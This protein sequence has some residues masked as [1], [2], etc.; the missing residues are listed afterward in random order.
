MT[1]P[2]R[3]QARRSTSNEFGLPSSDSSK[4]RLFLLVACIW[5]LLVFALFASSSPAA[6]APES[7]AR[8]DGTSVTATVQHNSLRSTFANALDRVDIMG[9]G[10]THPRVAVVIV[11]NNKDHLV[12][13]LESV[14]SSTDMNRIF[15]VCVVADGIAADKALAAELE[16]IDQGAIPHWHGLRPDLHTPS[17]EDNKEDD[18]HGRKVHVLFNPVEQ[19]I[20]ASRND[21]VQFIQI[22]SKYHEDAGLKSTQEDLILLLLASGAQLTSRRWLS[23]VTKALIVP[24]PIYDIADTTVSMKLANAVSFNVE[25]PGKRTSFDTSLQR[26]ITE[27]TADEVNLSSGASYPAPALNG[28]ATALR[29]DTYLNLPLQDFGMADPWA[30]DLD[31]ALNLWLCGDGIDMLSQVTVTAGQEQ[32]PPAPATA[33]LAGRFAAA[34]MDDGTSKKFFHAYA[35]KTNQADLT[36]LEWQTSEASAESSPTFTRDLPQKCRSFAW[37]AQEINPDLSDLLLQSEEVIVVEEQAAKD[38]EEATESRR[39][40]EIKPDLPT[41]PLP[42]PVVQEEPD[43]DDVSIPERTGDKQKPS[44]PLCE[45]CLEIIQKAKPVDITFVDVSGG[46][47]EHPHKG[48]L[49]ADGNF[50]FIH[51]E[52]A[53]HKNPPPFNFA[54]DELKHECAKRD[55]NYR[56][57][58]EQVKVDFDA[59]A[60]AEK[61]GRKRDKIFCLVYTID[62][63]HHKIP[64]IRETWGYVL[65][66]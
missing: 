45:E 29:L 42:P 8:G 34:W 48:A 5:P 44:K 49:D 64:L 39:E 50:G 32:T 60:E 37:Y 7:T 24:P 20:T 15:V 43:T 19:G 2:K 12:Q 25:G 6:I 3:P 35:A 1:V 36:Y 66:L 57:L 38:K 41:K 31:L 23:P 13:T 27:P 17:E 40:E 53:L 61:S 9:Y 52:K 54:G 4:A 65:S 30:A 18:P 14:F 26:M 47:K 33:E 59:E 63:G 21:A 58:N 11:G 56:M 46:H 55:N 16:K 62:S 28:A 51:D 22:L 10:P